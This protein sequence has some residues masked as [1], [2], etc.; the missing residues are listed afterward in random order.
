MTGIKRIGPGLKMD[1]KLVETIR[2]KRTLPRIIA[3]NSLNHF[4]EGFRSNGG[5]TDAGRWSRR[6]P[7]TRRDSGRNI[8]VD[9]GALRR[10]VRI[11]MTTFKRIVLG[12]ARTPYARRHNEG[13]KGMPKREFLGKSS[14][15]DAK[16]KELIQKQ[17]NRIY[18][19]A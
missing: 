1:K 2:L 13:L 8:L 3:N 9:T 10:D 19:W 15:L 7:G 14:K 18:K 4:L 6:K 5:Q 11:R 16:N 12:T 17:L